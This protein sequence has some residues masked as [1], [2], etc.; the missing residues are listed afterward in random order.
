[1]PPQV[2]PASH[3]SS[4]CALDGNPYWSSP[5]SSPPLVSHHGHSPCCC[6]SACFLPIRNV[7]E[8]RGLLPAPRWRWPRLP[9]GAGLRH[10][11]APPVSTKPPD[12]L[13][14]HPSRVQNKC[15]GRG[16]TCEAVLCLSTSSRLPSE[17]PS[18]TRDHNVLMSQI[19]R[20]GAICVPPHLC[21]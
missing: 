3:A 11:S 1:M 13:N 9:P 19:R 12:A 21:L 4:C 2:S 18:T 16:E 7:T 5:Y 14:Q 20:R 10:P 17:L 6:P 8:E 15:R